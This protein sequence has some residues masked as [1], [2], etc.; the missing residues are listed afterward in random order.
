MVESE[1]TEASD[2]EE[3]AV[4]GEGAGGSLCDTVPTNNVRKSGRVV[5]PPAW[6]NDYDMDV[7]VFA[8][9]AEEFIDN[10]PSDVSEL[11]KRGDWPSW[12]E[13]IKFGIWHKR[14]T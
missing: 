8:L 14:R 13:A 2:D 7:S 5:N 9:C 1:A 12:R 6:Q 11:K 3:G 10:I 4:G